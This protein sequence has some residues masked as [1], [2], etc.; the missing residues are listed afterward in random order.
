MSAERRAE[1][2]RECQG[3]PV[4]VAIYPKLA[5]GSELDPWEQLLC[6]KHWRRFHPDEPEPPEVQRPPGATRWPV[7]VDPDKAV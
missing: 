2:G 4:L 5:N 1:M 7:E 6:L 3:R